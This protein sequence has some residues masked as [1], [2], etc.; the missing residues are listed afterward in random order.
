MSNTLVTATTTARLSGE[1]GRALVTMRGHHL[2][3]D[4]PLALG[5][6]NEEVNPIDLLLGA[7]ATCATF[8]SEYV[9]REAQIPLA[10]IAVTVAGD[11][12]PRGMCGFPVDPKVQALRMQTRFTGPTAEQAAT[13]VQA[14][15]ARCPIFTTLAQT[16][17]IEI[18][19]I[20]EPS[21]VSLTSE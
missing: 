16:V 1:S 14:I 2:V 13:L 10:K 18:S 11:L 4:A 12:D 17:E 21:G 8:I 7:L 15:R 3:V 19:V 9:A 5:G 6:P 20:V